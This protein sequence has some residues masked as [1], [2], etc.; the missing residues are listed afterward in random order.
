MG[1]ALSLDPS[2][3]RTL[4]YQAQI[5]SAQNRWTEAEECF[6]RVLRLR[7]N[8]WLAYDELGNNYNDQGNYVDALAAYRAAAAAAPNR[9]IPF[10]NVASMLFQLG[11]FPEAL[12][13]IN[14]SIALAPLPGAYQTRS[15]I[16]RAQGRFSEALKSALESARLKPED[17]VSWLE[18]ADAYA[19]LPHR[20]QEAADAYQR[21]AQAQETQL[22]TQPGNGPGWM[23]LALYR[24]KIGDPGSALALVK[25]AESLGAAD[26]YSQLTK[27]RILELLG[28]REEALLTITASMRKGVTI[29]QIQ[30]T[31]DLDLLRTDPQFPT[32]P[33]SS[34]PKT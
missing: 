18:V 10:N 34:S 21:A 5:Y 25:K 31:H 32:N 7:P 3:T 8:Y 20:A 15:D 22:K 26:M 29:Y 30:A 24:I 28:R 6:K 23:L 13:A 19:L 16:L 14:R 1:V 27:L 33:M 9:A 11:T 2:D 17:S 4:T 12:A